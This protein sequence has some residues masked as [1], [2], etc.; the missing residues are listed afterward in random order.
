[1]Q[2]TAKANWKQWV[3]PG[4]G[5]CIDIIVTWLWSQTRRLLHNW[6]SVCCVPWDYDTLWCKW[7][8]TLRWHRPAS[9]WSLSCGPILSGATSVETQRER[10]RVSMGTLC[11]R[12]AGYYTASLFISVGQMTGE[13]KV[14]CTSIIPAEKF[15]TNQNIVISTNP[16]MRRIDRNNPETGL[17]LI[18][19]LKVCRQIQ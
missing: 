13:E 5:R 18:C 17:V 9:L 12:S 11:A 10:L 7:R 15:G 16:L 1:M 19:L 3:K 6:V 14:R 8:W 4:A 2:F